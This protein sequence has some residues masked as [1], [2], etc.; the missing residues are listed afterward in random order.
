MFVILFVIWYVD[1]IYLY[2]NFNNKKIINDNFFF[3]NF[4]IL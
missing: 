4:F 3:K 2:K 1:D